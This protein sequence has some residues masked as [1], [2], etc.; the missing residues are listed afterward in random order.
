MK[1]ILIFM[2]FFASNVKAEKYVID[3][4]SLTI[5]DKEI[6][7]IGIDAPEYNQTCFDDNNSEYDCG[8]EA[9]MFFSLCPQTLKY[10]YGIFLYRFFLE[11]QPK[12]HK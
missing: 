12:I 8:Q 11:M 5:G 7:L 9:Y 3:G 10:Q 6:R 2:L 1:F 4:D